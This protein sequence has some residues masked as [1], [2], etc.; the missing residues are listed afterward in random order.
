M[1][2]QNLIDNGTIRL[3]EPTTSLQSLVDVNEDSAQ[4]VRDAAQEIVAKLGI[5]Y[6][7]GEFRRLLSSFS[8]DEALVIIVDLGN[9]QA[10]GGPVS[11][12]DGVKGVVEVSVFFTT[13]FI[14]KNGDVEAVT[15]ERVLAHEIAHASDES[16]LDTQQPLDGS[17]PDPDYKGGAVNVANAI[18]TELSL[19]SER[20]SY[21]SVESFDY[22]GSPLGGEAEVD[23]WTEGKTV[24][25]VLVAED[26]DYDDEDGTLKASGPGP[27]INTSRNTATKD[28]LIIDDFQGNRDNEF[29]TGEGN[30]F[31]Y[32][33]DGKDTIDAGEGDD[34]VYGGLGSD[35]V[36]GGEGNDVLY[37]E[38][39]RPFIDLKDAAAID[40][41]DYCRVDGAFTVGLE[42]A[43]EDD[44]DAVLRIEHES[45]WVDLLQDFEIIKINGGETVFKTVDIE[46]FKVLVTEKIVAEN[47]NQPSAAIFD[48]SLL[49]QAIE[50]DFLQD[51]TKAVVKLK[52]DAVASSSA[53]TVSSENPDNA[54]EGLELKG[55]GGAIGTSQADTFISNGHAVRF[56]GGDGED[57][58]EISSNKGDGPAIVWGGDGG[59]QDIYKIDRN[60]VFDDVGYVVDPF[61]IMRVTCEGLT[62]ENFADFDFSDF[63]LG[64]DFDW[65]A[66]DL[67]IINPDEN[68]IIQ[69]TPETPGDDPITL[70]LETSDDFDEYLDVGARTPVID[71]LF[72]TTMYQDDDQNR[73]TYV[74][75]W[76]DVPFAQNGFSGPVFL[77]SDGTELVT[78]SPWNYETFGWTPSYDEFL[79]TLS[80]CWFMVGG[81]IDGT[82]IVAPQ[83]GGF[84][85]ALLDINLNIGTDGDDTQIGSGD[86]DDN[87]I[88]SLG[89]DSYDGLGGLDS[90]SYAHSGAAVTA[91]LA[92]NSASGGHAE[93]DSFSSIE[94]LSGSAFDD[95][96]I[97][98]AADNTL[99]GGDGDDTLTGYEG[100]DRLIG[101]FGN[102]HFRGNAG[103]DIIIGDLSGNL[104]GA[105]VAGNDI[106]SGHVGADTLIGD[107]GGDMTDTAQGGDDDL[108]GWQDDDIMIGDAA[109]D[110]RDDARGGDDGLGGGSGDDIVYGDAKGSLSGNAVGGA[111]TATGHSGADTLYGDA[112]GN[113]TGS[114]RGG[115]DNLAGW[116]DNDLLVGDAGGDLRGS[117]VGGDDVLGGGGGDDALYGDAQGSIA[118]TAVGGA[119]T[120]TGNS[121]DDLMIG[122]AGGDISGAAQGGADALSGWSGAD[123]MIG[124]AGGTMSGTA[125]GGIDSLHGH[126][127]ND[128]LYGDALG[129]MKDSAVGGDDYLRGWTDDDLIVGDTG[130][131]LIGSAR[132][133]NDELRG[134]QG[135]DTLYGDAIGADNG[136]G[137]ADRLSGGTDDD[138]LYGGSGADTFVFNA[139]DGSDVI[140]DYQDGIDKLDF[141]GSGLTFADLTITAGGNGEA[142]IAYGNG[143]QI[144]LQNAA[145]QLDASDFIF[146]VA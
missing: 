55:F 76:A 99:S 69:F 65:S 83:T 91:N 82:S 41:V 67:V 64:E 124:D 31:I 134:D 46:T 109:G 33:L 132:G 7:S 101:G 136:N 111:D 100:D 88:S 115:N 29:I 23:N 58:F 113:I 45:G 51:A 28:D 25:L 27:N 49:E 12:I 75:W 116:D 84:N 43:A 59:E 61:G 35:T 57:T 133:G 103:A 127:G 24:D 108:G 52:S 14:N 42:K 54:S 81:E 120:L 6:A 122:D 97:G 36:I 71:S 18:I 102:D 3:V 8:T 140:H 135:N 68:D 145:G 15:L 22:L 40:T 98:D 130:G 62:A 16:I 87:F 104:S 85:S 106:F 77:P 94:G 110:M 21:S 9:D 13:G 44:R 142:I 63:G 114:A 123:I 5:L 105:Q 129:D 80:Q 107:T 119:D 143:D 70:S 74:V 4:D 37:G 60:G 121:G 126:E 117:A 73:D 141:S 92:Q 26:S 138:N 2:I 78:P 47:C 32:G 112:G 96:L 128:S 1:S 146:A 131:A 79:L 93:G 90:V 50:V 139:G 118:D 125:T 19:G 30:D 95:T 89:G 38:D 137:G 86:R 34:H 17:I 53:S 66:I 11:D 20:T 72:G 56:A 10:R 39:I 48:G 144:T